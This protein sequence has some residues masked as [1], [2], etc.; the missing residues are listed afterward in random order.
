MFSPGYRL[1]LNRCWSADA[2]LAS[3]PHHRPRLGS[4]SLMFGDSSSTFMVYVPHIQYSVMAFLSCNT[5]TGPA[6]IIYH[7]QMVLRPRGVC[8]A[9]PDATSHSFRTSPS[10]TPFGSCA[11]KEGAY[12]S[13]RKDD[14][15]D[16]SFRE[17]FR[18]SS[19]KQKE[20]I[21]R[22]EDKK[23]RRE[24]L[25]A[26]HRGRSG[27]GGETTGVEERHSSGRV[28]RRTRGRICLCSL[29]VGRNRRVLI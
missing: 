11:P 15:N 8:G 28:L 2:L 21:G 26:E 20:I 17:I 24:V 6:T 13:L 9:F 5:Q 27:G 3:R 10:I 4:V 18:F 14:D 12:Q 19:H 7:F 25:I 1:D 16:K 23:K 29:A 22:P